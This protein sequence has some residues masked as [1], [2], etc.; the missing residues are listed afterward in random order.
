MKTSK[1][2]LPDVKCKQNEIPQKV[3][4]SKTLKFL[5]MAFIL[6]W[7]SF[8]PSC[9]LEMRTPRPGVS[10]ESHDRGGRHNRGNRYD[11]GNRHD[12][13]NHSEVIIRGDHN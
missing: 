5:L 11:R 7:V 2:I 1:I 3:R 4:G 12:R 9:M 10:V 6:S 8:L 13:G